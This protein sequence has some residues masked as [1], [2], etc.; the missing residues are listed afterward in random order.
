M[1]AVFYRELFRDLPPVDLPLSPKEVLHNVRR[2]VRSKTKETVKSQ[3][4]FALAWGAHTL[5]ESPGACLVSDRIEPLLPVQK[6]ACLLVL[7]VLS[8]TDSATPIHDQESPFLPLLVSDSLAVLQELKEDNVE[9]DCILEL[10]ESMLPTIVEG[11]LFKEI[12]AVVEE[13]KNVTDT[14]RVDL[15][16]T[17]HKWTYMYREENYVEPKI[18]AITESEESELGRIASQASEVPFPQERILTPLPSVGAPFCRPLPP[19]MLPIYSY[20]E[21]EQ[22]LNEEEKNDL[23]EYAHA[24][25]LWLTPTTLRVMLIPDNTAIPG[26][27]QEFKEIQHLLQNKAFSEPL[28]PKEERGILEVFRMKN[29]A[30]PP[31]ELAETRLKLFKDSGVTP[32]NLPKLVEHN[33]LVAH[34]C[35]LVV[36]QTSTETVKNEYLSALVGMDIT[37]HTMEVVNRLATHGMNGLGPREPF[38]HPEYVN[39][40]I[41][42]CIASCE[43]IQDR[44]SQNRLVRLVCVFIQSLLRNNIVHV[45]VNH[46]SYRWPSR[47]RVRL[48]RS[49]FVAQSLSIGHL[50]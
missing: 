2:H 7:E 12:T 10:V 18:W 5:L 48:A 6:L 21:D 37:L 42:S 24:D 9:K 46:D 29:L 17:I 50:F 14:V 36:M 43:N 47:R 27:L 31:A 11:P 4:P 40:F 8:S 16:S 39:L 20:E 38:L 41:T 33:P 23:M 15:E 19:P 26:K 34:E 22:P 35:L 44:N 3:S 49:L 13:N 32:L 25:L 1:A 28:S 45:Q 30:D